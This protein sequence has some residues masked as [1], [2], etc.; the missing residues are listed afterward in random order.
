MI[1]LGA[2]V[3]C[4]AIVSEKFSHHLTPKGFSAES[5]VIFRTQTSARVLA[6]EMWP[7]GFALDGRV[8]VEEKAS[9]VVIEPG[10]R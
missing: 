7:P 6:R 4:G 3:D 1:N 2:S 9:R 10:W 5:R 8:I